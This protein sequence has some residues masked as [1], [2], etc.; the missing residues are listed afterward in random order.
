MGADQSALSQTTLRSQRDEDIPFTSCSL[1]KPINTDGMTRLSPRIASSQPRLLTSRSSGVHNDIVVVTERSSSEPQID[2]E[3]ERLNA[4]PSFLPL[5]R[6]TVSQQLAA[7]TMD[8]SSSFSDRLYQLEPRHVLALCSRYQEHLFQ[9]AEAVNFDQNALCVRIKE[10]DF[11]IQS[12]YSVLQDQQ[13]RFAH[14]AEQIQKVTDVST[15]LN[16]VHMTIEQTIP[17]MQRLNSILPADEQLEPF[18]FN[19]SNVANH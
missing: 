6:G 7:L 5:L 1:S 3:I 18:T 11:A 14:Y 15:T 16:R 12:L 19:C 9:C 13:K 17:V 10:V 2:A 8:N 4:V